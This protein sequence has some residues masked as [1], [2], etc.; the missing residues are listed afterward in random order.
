MLVTPFPIS[1]LLMKAQLPREA[2]LWE[3]A[4]LL[5][6]LMRSGLGNHVLATM[7]CHWEFVVL[8]ITLLSL[9][10]LGLPWKRYPQWV[11]ITSGHRLHERRPDTRPRQFLPLVHGF[12][13]GLS[14]QLF[15]PRLPQ[16]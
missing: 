6:R 1:K 12:S 16:G 10:S 14:F 13:G 9:G 7:I 8:F 4:V 5:S 2:L 11:V 3:E 15:V